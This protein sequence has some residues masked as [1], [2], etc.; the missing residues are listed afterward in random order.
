MAGLGNAY[1]AGEG[2]SVFAVE[3]HTLYRRE[4]SLGDALA[5]PVMAGRRRRQAA[6]FGA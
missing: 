4:V 6:A 1:R 3:T 5:V 2:C